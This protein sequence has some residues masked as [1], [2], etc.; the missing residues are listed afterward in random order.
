MAS[1]ADKTGAVPG[2]GV[3]RVVASPAALDLIAVLSGEYG[4]ILFHQSGGCC[5][6]S[7]P[8]CFPKNEFAV[9]EADVLLG[10]IGGAPFYIGRAQFEY[11]Q[12]TQLLSTLCPAAE[13][14]FRS[15]TAGTCG[16]SRVHASIPKKKT[17]LLLRYRD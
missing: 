17:R 7:S 9:A 2:G 14:C 15:R 1:G 10:H 3:P 4:A 6:G 13:G 8:M 12:H 5:D 11:W 16:F